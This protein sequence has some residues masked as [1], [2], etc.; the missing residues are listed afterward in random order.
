[1]H[2]ER[3]LLYESGELSAEDAAAFERHLDSCAG[4]REWLAVVR[5]G[6]AWA[7]A[8]ASEPPG[9]A[10]SSVASRLDDSRAGGRRRA[11]LA[12]M[13]LAL[14]FACLALLVYQ[15]RGP[16]PP[17]PTPDAR[18][19]EVMPHWKMNLLLADIER[20]EERIASLREEIR[21]TQSWSTG[22]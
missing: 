10:V 4:C 8:R 7:E 20:T 3:C 22:E 5:C 11:F 2:K 17:A 1:M 9:G 14:G 6:H 12:P 18:I 15:K 16:R 13:T 19:S 21:L